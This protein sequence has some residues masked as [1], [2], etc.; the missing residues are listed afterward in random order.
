MELEDATNWSKEYKLLIWSVAT[1]AFFGSFRCGELLSKKANS[2]DPEV[3]LQ[4]KDIMVVKRFVNKK[5]VEPLEV[6]L[7]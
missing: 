5:K 3:D 6:N 7:K 1:L 2:I 4:L